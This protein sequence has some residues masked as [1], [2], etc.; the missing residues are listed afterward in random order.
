[1][2]PSRPNSIRCQKS[3]CWHPPFPSR[4]A[5]EAGLLHPQSVWLLSSTNHWHCMNLE[6]LPKP[7]LPV[8]P[9]PTSLSQVSAPSVWH[10]TEKRI[11]NSELSLPFPYFCAHTNTLKLLVWCDHLRPARSQLLAP[12]TPC[13]DTSEQE[14]W[15]S[16]PPGFVKRCLSPSDKICCLYDG[17]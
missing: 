12:I 15:P 4:S 11:I 7:I 2:W 5:D 17:I 3:R 16:Q 1:M 8:S 6:M 13:K 10:R 9:F 14:T